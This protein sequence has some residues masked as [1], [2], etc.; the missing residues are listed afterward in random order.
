MMGEA[1]MY[2]DDTAQ[3]PEKINIRSK[4]FVTSVLV[5]MAV[6]VA[7]TVFVLPIRLG[8][9]LGVLVAAYLAK[10][11]TPKDGA[12]IG[13]VAVIP[14]GIYAAISSVNQTNAMASLGILGAITYGFVNIVFMEGIGAIYGL[15]IGKIFQWTR[16]RSVIL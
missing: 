11:Q 13:M 1:L 8:A 16:G 4:L 6:G 5:G 7:L 14:L 10:A 15:I 2:I 9:L 3:L 12:L